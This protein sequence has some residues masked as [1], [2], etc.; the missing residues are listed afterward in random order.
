VQPRRLAATRT[1]A[2]AEPDTIAVIPRA[3]LP[4]VIGISSMLVR[5]SEVRAFIDVAR[6]FAVVAH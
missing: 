6:E 3:L 2:F 1:R 5:S 4:S